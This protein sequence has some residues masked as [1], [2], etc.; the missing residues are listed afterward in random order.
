MTTEKH[1]VWMDRG[2]GLELKFKIS[3]TLEMDSDTS[4]KMH[5]W[6][7]LRDIK[8]LKR[9]LIG[10]E[11]SIQVSINGTKYPLELFIEGVEWDSSNV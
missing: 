3:A 1:C 10:M 8:Q 5:D 4:K 9:H 7:N 6:E 11:Q 2:K